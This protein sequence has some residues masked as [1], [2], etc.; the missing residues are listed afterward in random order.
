MAD[1]EKA[2]KLDNGMDDESIEDE[3]VS[4][5]AKAAM[6][7]ELLK[8]PALFS[9]M[10]ADYISS[11][12]APVKRRLKALK[13]IQLESTKIEAKFYEEVHKLECKYHQMYQPLYQKRAGITKGDYEP[14]DDECQWPS[15][16]EGKSKPSAKPLNKH[17]YFD[18]EGE[19]DLAKD[20]KDKAKIEDEKTKNDTEEG[21]DVK[22]VPDF[23]LT[24]FKN[25]DMLQ[26]MVQ[27]E[28]EPVLSKL[29]DITVT[30]SE[31]P[32]G[33]TLHFYF[34]L[35][36]YFT[37]SVLTKEYEM[38]CEPSEDDPFGFEGPEIFKCKGSKINWKEPGKDL[39]VKTVKKKQKHKSKGNVRTITKQVKSDSFF[40]FFDPPPISDNPDEDIDPETQDLLTADFEIGHYIRDRI[41][42]RAV[43]YFTGEALE[44]EEEEEDFDEEGEEGEE[45]EDE[46]D[47]DFDPSKVK[48]GQN[49]QECKQQ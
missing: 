33:F 22:G 47:P 23:W 45:E 8:N 14:N 39:T 2:T 16:D 1:P 3:E 13:K 19:E 26:E 6:V 40:N 20:M 12:P 11:L 34:A 21:K 30:F 15:D 9:I 31:T 5:N 18:S 43:L 38:K 25:V 7:A 41:I 29:T 46:N 32:M 48:P 35:N 36:D 37:N 42:P 44:E 4:T 49:A 17:I 27:E 28:D 10:N 24:I